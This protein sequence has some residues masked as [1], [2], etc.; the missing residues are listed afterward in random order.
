MYSTAVLLS[1]VKPTGTGYS[2][3]TT[4]SESMNSTHS[5]TRCL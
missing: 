2:K 1:A 5:F 3:E 4:K